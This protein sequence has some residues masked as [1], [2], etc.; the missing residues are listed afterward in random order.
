M[1]RLAFVVAAVAVVGPAAAQTADRPALRELVT[2]RPDKTEAPQTIDVGHLQLEF[3]VASF[4]HDRGGGVTTETVAAVPFN[5]KYG[6]GPST[7]VQLVVSPWQRV[8]VTDR[9]S[10]K[11]TSVHGFGDVAVR[12]KHNLWGNDGGPT[13]MAVM[14]F[15][16]LPTARRG[17]GADGIEFGLIVPV[18]VRLTDAI[19]LGAMTEVDGLRDG[20]RYRA[21]FVNSATLGFDLTGRLGLYTELYTE[22]DRDW[23][24]TGDA[25]LTYRI[26]DDL[27]LDG[28]VNVG[29]T[30][31]AD[32]IGLF[33]GV[34]RRF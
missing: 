1:R 5:L 28:G 23:I 25:G 15:V 8:V 2:D 31:A 18:S 3:D 19:D 24:V 22:H 34:S 16:T 7:D 20:G 21:S 6:V 26:G 33:V 10:G 27:Q 32:D 14:P 9:A 13:A 4:T 29:L 30:E 11:R 12:L 17:L